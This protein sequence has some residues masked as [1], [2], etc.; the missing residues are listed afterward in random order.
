MARKGLI[1]LILAVLVATGAFAQKNTITYDVGPTLVGLGFNALENIIPED[2]VSGN[3]LGFAFQYERDLRQNL[4]V[5][6]RFAYL[7]IDGSFS[8][9]NLGIGLGLDMDMSSYSI[10]GHVRYY[11][12]GE[13]FFLDGTLGYANFSAVFNGQAIINNVPRVIRFD[14]S[15]NYLKVGAKLGWRIS[16]GSSG[17]FTIEPAFGYYHGIALGDS[18]GKQFADR[19]PGEGDIKNLF[20]MFEKYMFVSGPRM[21]LGFGW[22]F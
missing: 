2:G 5:A 16:L 3:G 19:F 20:D 8:D 11:P 13:T 10:E 12:F 22:R 14:E 6:G 21:S 7:S 1:I 18:V 17:G 9:N 15:A 4:S